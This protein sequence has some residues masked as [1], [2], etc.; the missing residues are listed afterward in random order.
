MALRLTFLS[1]DGRL[2]FAAPPG[3]RLMGPLQRRHQP[4][5]RGFVL[6]VVLGD[7]LGKD[8]ANDIAQVTLSGGRIYDAQDSVCDFLNVR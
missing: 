7:T 4:C 1:V 2:W 3:N 5:L 6:L 8:G